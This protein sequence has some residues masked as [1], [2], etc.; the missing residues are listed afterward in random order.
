MSGI[1]MS[2]EAIEACSLLTDKKQYRYVILGFSD[3]KT[4][5]VVKNIGERDAPF[6]Q[7]LNDVPKDHV[8]YIIYDCEYKT[9]SGQDRQKVFLASWSSDDYAPIKEKMMVPTSVSAV[10]NCV[11]KIAKKFTI[12]NWDDLAEENFINIVSENRTK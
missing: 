5:I 1:N 11:K 3:D 4:S 8:R 7:L 6:S 12:N 9:T 10:T 2:E